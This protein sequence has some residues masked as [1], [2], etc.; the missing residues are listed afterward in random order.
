VSQKKKI[1]TIESPRDAFQS[2]AKIVSTSVKIEYINLLLQVGFDVVDFGSIVSPKAIPNMA[3]SL[4]VLQNLDVSANRTKLMV[5][6]PNVKGAQIAAK[7]E[8]IT[9]ISYPFSASPTF[10]EKNIN[11]TQKQGFDDLLRIKELCVKSDKEFYPYLSMAF[12][13]P[14]GDKWHIDMLMEWAEKF[15]REDILRISLSDIVGVA[16]AKRVAVVYHELYS[17]FEKMDFGLHLH[18]KKK[19]A[20]AKLEAAFA[21][22]VQTVDTVL[23]G[24]GG[25]PMTGYELLENLD[26]QLFVDFCRENEIET[27]ID[28]DKLLEAKNYLVKHIFI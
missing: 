18:T 22:G 15:R 13:N 24:L 8:K 20:T 12:G 27:S 11:R 26:T 28:R 4:D 10:I 23:G 14:Y 7:E 19:E 17:E 25:C 6:V 2:Y 21:N 16:D 5:L 9:F 1:T 3:D